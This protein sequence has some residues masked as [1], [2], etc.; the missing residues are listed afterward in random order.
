MKLIVQVLKYGLAFLAVLIGIGSGYQWFAA[1]QDSKKY[2]PPGELYTVNGLQVHLDC[3][4]QGRPA[5]IMEAGLTFGSTSWGIVHDALAKQTQ[6]CAY[7]RPGIDWSEQTDQPLSAQAVA[8]RLHALLVQ[9]GIEGPKVLLGMSAGGVFVREYFAKYPDHIAGMVLVDSSHE[10]QGSRLPALGS[11]SELSST[12]A[13]CS[14]VQPLGLIR[15]LGFME[16]MLAR[17]ELQPARQQLLRANMN[18]NHTCAAML[19]E[20]EGFNREIFDPQPP[21]SLGNLPLLVLSQGKEPEADNEFG[22]P[23]EEARELAV[24]WDGLQTELTQLSSVGQRHIALQS[25][26]VIQFEQPQIIIEKV[27]EMLITLRL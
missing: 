1:S 27:S 25:G 4:G 16:D 13:L 10:Q 5:I 19:R 9:A 2:P 23:L 15:A 12:L 14:W 21:R 3:R 20:S 8:D 24:I 26:H 22:L 18:Q 6:V 17:Y 11:T 7:D